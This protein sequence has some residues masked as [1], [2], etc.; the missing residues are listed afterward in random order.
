MGLGVVPGVVCSGKGVLG[1]WLPPA[2]KQAL[3]Y[4]FP[5]VFSNREG[6]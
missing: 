6:G 1:S 2:S 5:P 3:F 4:C